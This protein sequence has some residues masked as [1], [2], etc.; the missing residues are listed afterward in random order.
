MK[1]NHIWSNPPIHGDPVCL[2]CGQDWHS[3]KP[4]A[5]CA[6]KLRRLPKRRQES[7]PHE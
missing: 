2:K 7:L 4:T 1:D 3:R 5:K 6:M